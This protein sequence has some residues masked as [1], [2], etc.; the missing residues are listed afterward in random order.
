YTLAHTDPA[1]IHQYVEDAFTAQSADEHTSDISLVFALVGLYLHVDKGLS[2]RQVQLA[3]MRL[4]HRKRKWPTMVVPRDRG[5]MTEADVIRA[6]PGPER[7]NAIDAW[8]VS[9]W[10]AFRGNEPVV[11][12]LLAEYGM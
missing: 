11:V 5:D 7:D 9:V 12:A 6:A 10:N 3:H 4:A 2:G 1:F 8:C